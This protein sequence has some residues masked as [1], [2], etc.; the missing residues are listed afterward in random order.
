M[1]V[2]GNMLRSKPAVAALGT[3]AQLPSFSDIEAALLDKNGHMP[4][5]K[6]FFFR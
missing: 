1:R 5:R 3:L 2:A 4:T 6:R